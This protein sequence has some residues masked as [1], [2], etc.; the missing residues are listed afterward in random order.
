MNN[1]SI[2]LLPVLLFFLFTVLIRAQQPPADLVV[3]N[4][5]I[6]TVDSKRFWA[7]ALAIK[8]GRLVFVGDDQSAV[9]YIGRNTKV[10]DVGG[11]LILPGFHDTHVHLTLADSRQQ[12]CDLGYPSTLTATRQAIVA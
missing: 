10:V 12:W 4:A 9:N 5:N 2:L 7:Q 3:Q 6:Y 1:K 11:R 8:N